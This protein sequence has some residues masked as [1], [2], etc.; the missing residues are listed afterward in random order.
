MG[1]KDDKEPDREE[2]LPEIGTDASVV[3]YDPLQR[4]LMEIRRYSLL[5]VEEERELAKKY[6]EEG[7]VDAAYKLVTSNLRLVVKIALEFSRHW[8]ANALD[9]I[10]EGNVGL[11][12]AVKKFDP[13]KEVKLSTYASFWVRAYILKFIVDN[14]RLVKVGTTQAQRKLFYNLKK[15]KARLTAL[16]FD[17]TPKLVAK[18]LDVKEREVVEMSQRLSHQEQ[19]L[20]VSV[21]EDS[22]ETRVALVPSGEASVDERMVESELKELFHEKL[23]EARKLLNDKELFILEKRLLAER[24][25]TLQE[26]GDK[27]GITRERVRQIE[28][29]LIKKIRAFLEKEIPD[30]D[31]AHFTMGR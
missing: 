24:S 29:R 16:G 17:A 8:M 31:E 19:S 5:S 14:W 22:R 2:V 30:F 20:D 3:R 13:G 6:R 15:E 21:D 1:K 28:E 9:L 18:Q 25:L 10:Q 4:Y 26:V 11:M 27:Y 23:G 12:M 7:D